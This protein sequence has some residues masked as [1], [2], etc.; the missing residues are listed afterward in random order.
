MSPAAGSMPL[1]RHCPFRPSCS[2]ARL[3][4]KRC[5]SSSAG[6][7]ADI[8]TVIG[9]EVRRVCASAAPAP[10]SRKIP[11]DRQ[12]SWPSARP[13]LRLPRHDIGRAVFRHALLHEGPSALDDD[14]VDIAARSASCV[15][16][17]PC[18]LETTRP[19]CNEVVRQRDRRRG[20]KYKSAREN[21]FHDGS[22]L[23]Q[24]RWKLRGRRFDGLKARFDLAPAREPT[25][26]TIPPPDRCRLLD[27]HSDFHARCAAIVTGESGSMSVGAHVQQMKQA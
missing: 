13:V 1:R 27:D 26:Y 16:S 24:C 11:L 10:F 14:P 25:R 20:E 8:N 2:A 5:S 15:D 19:F 6:K 4:I 23:G 9:S 17:I 3:S 12:L 7:T 18:K 21:S 22:H